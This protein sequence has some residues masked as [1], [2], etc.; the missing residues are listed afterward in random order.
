MSSFYCHA[1]AQYVA[2]SISETTF[3]LDCAECG[4]SAVEVAG[5][6]L[7]AFLAPESRTRVSPAASAESSSSRGGSLLGSAGAAGQS[8]TELLHHIVGRVLVRYIS[9]SGEPSDAA[10][11]WTCRS[12]RRRAPRCSACCRPRSPSDRGRRWG[13]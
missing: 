11:E 7:E 10:R 8:R 2:A 6:G 5:Q 4:S 13:S 3:E 9:S 1:C 12:A